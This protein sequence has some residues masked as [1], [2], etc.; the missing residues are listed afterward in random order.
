MNTIIG[1]VATRY[2]Y[3]EV[4]M[5]AYGAPSRAAAGKYAGSGSRQLCQNVVSM[6]T[7]R[8]VPR[9]AVHAAR[10]NIPVTAGTSS[11][12]VTCPG[13]AR[14]T[15]GEGKVAREGSVEQAVCMRVAGSTRAVVPLQVVP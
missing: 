9:T 12:N 3:A 14:E 1:D 10:R 7:T 4:D 11:G 5:V 6:S 8:N 13:R 15:G 2:R